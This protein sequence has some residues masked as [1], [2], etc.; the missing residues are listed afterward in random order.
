[1]SIYACHEQLKLVSFFGDRSLQIKVC[2][3]FVDKGA[4]FLNAFLY[5]YVDKYE[6]KLE[7]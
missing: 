2:F 3:M 5:R 6:D 4:R 7:K 1:M